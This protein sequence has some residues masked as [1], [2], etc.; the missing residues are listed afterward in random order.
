MEKKNNI[1]NIEFR[2]GRVKNILKF[3]TFDVDCIIVDPPR[4]GIV[5]K[6]LKR[7]CDLKCKNL[8]YVS[9]HPVTLLRDLESFKEN[10]YIV[11]RII[12]V[13]MFPNTFHIESVVKLELN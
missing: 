10:G 11:K 5:T 8:I 6:A 3:E 1:S 4:S 7:I 12:P 9:C 2:C 13:D